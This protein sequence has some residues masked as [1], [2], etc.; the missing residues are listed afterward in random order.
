MKHHRLAWTSTDD[1]LRQVR[2]HGVTT[3]EHH[4]GE[5][6]LHIH[7]LE[8]AKPEVVA[9]R[10]SERMSALYRFDLVVRA[11]GSEEGMRAA[12]L[13]KE[14][15][16]TM[17][18]DGG[19]RVV[20]GIAAHVELLSFAEDRGAY[21]VVLMPKLWLL[22]KRQDTRVFQDKTVRQIVAEVLNHH[23]ITHY[24]SLSR[25]YQRRAYCL[26]Y[27]ETD[28]DF[29]ARLMAEEG[30]FYCFEQPTS[31][32]ALHEMQLSTLP[33][34]IASEA[35]G[36]A[37]GG[38]LSAEGLLGAATNIV[39]PASLLQ[40][41]E[42]N[43]LSELL[44]IGDTPVVYAA[45]EGGEELVAAADSSGALRSDPRNVHDFSVASSVSPTRSTVR[46]YDY[47][48]AGQP[49][50]EKIGTT[51][52]GLSG[53][54]SDIAS[55][56]MQ[57]AGGLLGQGL[58][59]LGPAGAAI[60]NVGGALGV[61]MNNPLERL[62]QANEH[63]RH[64][65]L[66]A[67]H[68]VM[69][70]ETALARTGVALGAA[71]LQEVIDNEVVD[72]IVGGLGD[73]GAGLVSGEEDHLE[74]YDHH[75]DF[76]EPEAAL[77]TARSRL[78]QHRA[79]YVVCSGSTHCRALAPGHSF[80]LTS[81]ALTHLNR[82]YALTE[83]V[84][85]GVSHATGDRPVYLNVFRCVPKEI[86]YRP[87]RPPRR[88]HQ[89]VE[90]GVVVGHEHA[91]IETERF[92]CVKVQF[93]WN[94]EQEH[95]EHSSCWIRVMQPWA[96]GAY[97]FQFIP[98]VGMEVLVSFIG[99]DVDRPVVIGC[100]PNLANQPPHPLPDNKTR[101]AIRTQS[102]PEGD[103]G[104]NE[105]AF[106]DQ[107]DCEEIS[108]H[109]QHNLV[110]RIRHDHRTTVEHNREKRVAG[111]ELVRVEH[112]R[113]V[114]VG[115][116]LTTE[117]NG[118]RNDRTTHEHMTQVGTDRHLHVTGNQHVHVGEGHYLD[119]GTTL[120]LRARSMS[121]SAE[122]HLDLSAHGEEGTSSLS[123][124]HDMVRLSA[125][126]I[127]IAADTQ[128]NITCG[129]SHISMS[130]DSVTVRS[131]KLTLSAK[132]L[133]LTTDDG[134]TIDMSDQIVVSSEKVS[135]V[136][137]GAI[138]RLDANAAI[139]G[140]QVSL[141]TGDASGDT[142]ED[143][144]SEEETQPLSMRFLNAGGEPYAD[145]R[146]LMVIGGR[147]YRGTT[148][149]NGG[150]NE[151]VPAD[152]TDGRITVWTTESY[153]NG[154][155]RSWPVRIGEVEGADGVAGA[156]ARLNN[157]GYSAGEGDEPDHRY[158]QAL[159]AF[160]RDNGLTVNGELNSETSDALSSEHSH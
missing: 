113:T 12:A 108:I 99:G 84:H 21:H 95:D 157:L 31:V 107:K 34:A 138:V 36:L 112:N 132:H 62:G 98:R 155:S 159:R 125:P 75:A 13:G 133:V 39:Q 7:G 5:F 89:T 90:T 81:H 66:T 68:A 123:A 67:T 38:E 23:G 119:A 73:F 27:E 122:G 146:Y 54:M 152:A 143:E 33:G 15:K 117:V 4:S 65:V 32:D 41:V 58:G 78:E 30:I 154:P 25:E 70:I 131:E 72:G 110:E 40:M 53:A 49:Q 114:T 126:T 56:G 141:C 96:G 128:V 144:E 45:A 24:V 88:V 100:L 115:H 44:I 20:Y 57:A 17:R 160:Q 6:H 43:G 55:A 14:L 135:L 59:A 145:R 106:E 87:P 37:R 35:M 136:S 10:G 86:P 140:G 120:S 80:A 85:E 104:Y 127:N 156:R 69:P 142:P 16:L 137:S 1:M 130:G 116:D 8:G 147:E 47:K 151:D 26:Q 149:G 109:A 121:I 93:H 42:A 18:R 71:V 92:G 63:H 102:T 46:S 28:Y 51:A 11:H 79:G 64:G 83:V 74:I 105:I 60:G 97:G 9:F 2:G 94:R 52:E 148:D 29:V 153:P 61:N 50:N 91:E 101:S 76:E 124:G 158:A 150:I 134:S 139:D 77:R 129:D 48:R 118:A 82:E 3:S 22:T 103:G 111:D 19:E